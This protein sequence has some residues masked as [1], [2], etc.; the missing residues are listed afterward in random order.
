MRQWLAVLL[1][2]AAVLTCPAASAQD[3]AAALAGLIDRHIQARLDVE[4][5]Q[6]VQN[7]DDAEFLRRVF[8]DLHGVVPSAK[9]AAAFLDTTDPEERAHLIEELLDSPRFGEHLGDV[10]RGR[11]ISPLVNE[12]RAQ[13]E[14]FADWLA[15]RFNHNDGWDRIVYDLLTAAGKIEE[16][17]AVTYLIEG[18]NPLSVADLTDLSSRYFLGVRLNCVQ[19]HDHPF[20][21]WKQQDY[22]GMAAFFAQIQTPG[23][24]KMVYRVGVQDDPQMTLASLRDGDMID[25]FQM[26]PPTFLGGGEFKAAG[27]ETHRAAL[28]RWITSPEN[29]YFARAAVNRMWCHFFGRGIVNPVDDMHAAN[30]PSHPELLELLS[31]R[32]AESGF[33][34]KFLCRAIVS[35]RTYQQTSRPGDQPDAEAR[36]FGRMSVK[37]LSA[38]QLYDSLVT[39]L[40][41]PGK[42]PGIDA[43]L[44][45]RY[46]FCQFFAAEGNPDPT[47]YERGIPHLLRLMNSPQFAGRNLDALVARVAVAGRSSDEV[48]EELFLTILARRPTPAERQIARDEARDREASPNAA[49]RELAW[50]LLMSSEFSLNH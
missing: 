24:P 22:W 42:A 39:I 35:S 48:T 9:T 15:H 26:R 10:W 6:R 23:R 40:G 27:D 30:P 29:P 16:N 5:V 2:I 46:E 49:Y 8:L 28:A 33:D 7:A 41:T 17:P 12:Q 4:G 37:V 18:R 13:S 25:G 47:R 38:E 50:A 19:C 3:D 21:D 31:R 43:R 44:G 1:F 36:L 45:A 20:V 14:R 34:L 32:F 11:L